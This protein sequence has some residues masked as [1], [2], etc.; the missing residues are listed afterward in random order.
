MKN[1]R[2][3]NGISKIEKDLVFFNKI[4]YFSFVLSMLRDK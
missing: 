1:N 3:S 2:V 4:N